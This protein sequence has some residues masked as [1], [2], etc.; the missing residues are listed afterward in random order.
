MTEE[1]STNPPPQTTEIKPFKEKLI[2]QKTEFEMRTDNLLTKLKPYP[3]YRWLAFA[4][5][6]ILFTVRMFATGKYY[7]VGYISGFVLLE[8][9]LKFLSPKLDPDVYGKDVLPYASE[10]GDYKPF[11]RKLPEFLFWK[12]A[13]LTA[14]VA[15]IASLIPLFDLPVQGTILLVYFLIV[16]ILSFRQRISHMIRNHYLPFD[17][18]KKTLVK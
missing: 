7:A 3:L 5:F 6:S 2:I 9:F 1:I 10:D 17:L 8:G 11:I 16:S 12:Q 15:T 18:G 4:F 14:L 13:M